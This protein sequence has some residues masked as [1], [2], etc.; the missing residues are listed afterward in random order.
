KQ[1]SWTLVFCLFNLNPATRPNSEISSKALF[2]LG[3]G[4]CNVKT[5]SSAKAFSLYCFPPTCIP[6]TRWSFLI[7][8]SKTSR[9]EIN[10]KG[11][12]GHPCRVP[13]SGEGKYFRPVEESC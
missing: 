9:T 2:V 10:S 1:H 4:S 8:F 11:D 13:F 3:S 12:K 5:K 6:S 7:K